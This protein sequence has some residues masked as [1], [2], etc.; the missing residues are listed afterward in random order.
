MVHCFEL[1]GSIVFSNVLLETKVWTD[2]I[3]GKIY[4]RDHMEW[5]NV[6][7]RKGILPEDQ[8]KKIN[9]DKFTQH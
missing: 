3:L 7:T 1:H 6:R 5:R 2:P 8:H 4:F 9:L